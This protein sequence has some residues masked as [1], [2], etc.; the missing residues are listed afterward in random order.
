[1]KMKIWKQ[2]ASEEGKEISE[3]ER[4]QRLMMYVGADHVLRKVLLLELIESEMDRLKSRLSQLYLDNLVELRKPIDG[5]QEWL[6]AVSR[7]GIPCVVVSSRDRISTVKS[8]ERMGLKK[9][10]QAIVSKEDGMESIAHRF[11]SAAVKL[12]RK[13]SK[14]VVFEDDP[15]GV[16][17]AHNCTM[18]AVALIGVHP[19]YELVQADLAVVI[20][21]ELLVIN[22]RRLYANKG[23]TFMDREKKRI[24]KS[25]PK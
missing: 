18:M 6:H 5:L 10:F 20:Y 7:S 1:M 2:F 14:C 8:L 15:R 13:P 25:H 17:A 16:T 19:A 11:L 21:N 9:Y 12:D 22:L 24:K 4:V 3:D 23:S